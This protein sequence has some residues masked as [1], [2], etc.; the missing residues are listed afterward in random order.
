MAKKKSTAKKKPAVSVANGKNTAEVSAKL[1]RVRRTKDDKTP[2]GRATIAQRTAFRKQHKRTILACFVMAFLLLLAFFF[3][4]CVQGY[5]FSALVCLCLT[6]VIGFYTFV[7]KLKSQYPKFTRTV[8]RIFTIILC[9]GLLVVGIT[10]ALIIQASFGNP[11]AEC[12][13][14]LVLGAKV[15][16]D[17]PSLS[18]MNRINAAF[19]YLTAHPDAIA[20][21]SGGQGSDEPMTEAQCMYDHLTAMGIDPSRIWM[22]DKATSTWEN[23]LYS[24]DLIEEKTGQRPETLAVLSSEYHLFRAKLFTEKAGAEFI[25]VPARTTNPVLMVNYFLRE[26]AGVWHYI[27][28]GSLGGHYHA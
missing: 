24:L 26:V 6:A 2:S 8:I 21:V 27:L 19:D 23:L 13:Y 12:A 17:G 10:E 28:L 1:N 11:E 22:E 16:S 4:F 14:L 15:R 9:I 7:P 5:S 25:G 3:K 18:L 20:V